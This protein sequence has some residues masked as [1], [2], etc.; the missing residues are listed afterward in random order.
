MEK[1]YQHADLANGRWAQMSVVEQ[2]ANIG[3][4]VD[5]A[6]HWRNKNNRQLCLNAVNRAFEL[7]D[8]TL[9]STRHYPTLKEFARAREV[10]ADY[11]Y[12]ENEY[13]STEAWL[14]KYF[15]QFAMALRKNY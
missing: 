14:R 3:S 6:F 13:H 5:R 2:M 10:L 9:A 4:E 15:L 11:F 7:I 8:L 1:K 12:A